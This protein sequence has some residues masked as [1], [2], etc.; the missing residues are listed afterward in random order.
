VIA[1]GCVPVTNIDHEEDILS[2]TITT[3]ATELKTLEDMS[4]LVEI[5]DEMGNHMTNMSDISLKSVH[6]VATG[7]K[8]V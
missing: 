1:S 3:T 7:V 8:S 6:Q 4:F 2:A 5:K